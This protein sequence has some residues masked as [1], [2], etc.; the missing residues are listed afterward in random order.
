[1]SFYKPKNRVVTAVT[2]G[3]SVGVVVG[4]AGVDKRRWKSFYST[5]ESLSRAE[6]ELA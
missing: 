4:A 6:F 5:R 2:G 1:M 3:A